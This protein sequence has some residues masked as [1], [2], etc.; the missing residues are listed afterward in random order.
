MLS[1]NGSDEGVA[2]IQA[3][4]HEDRLED[5]LANRAASMCKH[6]ML[7]NPKLAV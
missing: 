1:F 7:A 4:L 6:A 3:T 2:Q 5:G